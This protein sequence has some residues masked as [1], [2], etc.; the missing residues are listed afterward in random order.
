M[1]GYHTGEATRVCF[2]RFT[3][4]TGKVG[5]GALIILFRSNRT[6]YTLIAQ[7]HRPFM[8]FMAKPVP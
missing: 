5:S 2:D 1:S 8:A 4:D 7:L 6:V 3:L